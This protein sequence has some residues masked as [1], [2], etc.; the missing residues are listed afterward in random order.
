MMV[1]VNW[2][3]DNTLG[4]SL[5]ILSGKS[6]QR[7]PSENHVP[8][9]R[10]TGRADCNEADNRPRDERQKTKVDKFQGMNIFSK[11]H[12]SFKYQTV[13][14]RLLSQLEDDGRRSIHARL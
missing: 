13:I 7:A 14:D 9:P 3:C 6:V 4:P 10:A 12:L 5:H 8:C 11:T 1:C 2:N